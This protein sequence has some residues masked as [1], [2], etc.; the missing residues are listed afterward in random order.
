MDYKVFLALGANIG[1]REG[2]L[3]KAIH[4]ISKLENIKLEAVSKVYETVPVGYIEQPMFLNISVS[5]LTNILPLD[6][7]EYLQE[8]E[9]SLDR[10]RNIHWGPR[11]ID[12][13]ILLYGDKKIN[14]PNLLIPHPRMYERAFVL[15][16]LKDIYGNDK[17]NGDRFDELIDKCSDKYGV[18]LY[19]EQRVKYW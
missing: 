11:T 17:I 18:R 4:K 16:P 9:K 14:T 7:L 8:V 19:K 3:I 6:L 15:N 13:D 2:Y 12:I 10:V 1:D 5:V